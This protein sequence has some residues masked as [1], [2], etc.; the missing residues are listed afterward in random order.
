MWRRKID[1]CTPNSSQI[2]DCRVN[3]TDEERRQC[4]ETNGIKKFQ[5]RS[6]MTPEQRIQSSLT[7]SVGAYSQRNYLDR[8]IQIN[9]INVTKEFEINVWG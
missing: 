2:H 3:E 4:L 5:V 1:G 8:R 7:R 6:I 9:E